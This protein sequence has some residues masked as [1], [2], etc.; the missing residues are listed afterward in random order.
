M[1]IRSIQPVVVLVAG[2][3]FSG[4]ANAHPGHGLS[5]LD[6]VAHP[7]LGLDHV[8]AMLAVGVWAAQIGGRAGGHVIW[9]V[10]L[11]FVLLMVFGTGM[12][13]SGGAF[14]MVEGGIATSVLLLGLLVAFSIKARPI[15]AAMLV[16]M[17]AIFHGCAHGLEVPMGENP[18]RFGMGFLMST[19]GLHVAGLLLGLRLRHQHVWLRAIGC[20]VASSGAFLLI[21]NPL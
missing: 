7:L 8:L 20:I 13:I 16:G 3:L 2:L 14:P 12:A 10:P 11:S 15:F 18:W 4:M 1:L 17:F 5:Y 9:A 21:S 19:I 6:G